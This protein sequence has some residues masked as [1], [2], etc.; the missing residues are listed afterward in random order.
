MN[1]LKQKLNQDLCL[2]TWVSSG[3]SA[4][5]E[6]AARSGFDWVLIDCEH[7]MG[8]YTDLVHQ[9][10]AIGQHTSTELRIDWMFRKAFARQA[11]AQEK[12]VA[13]EFVQVQAIKRGVKETDIELWADLTHALINT[14]E[15][16]FLR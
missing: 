10:Q 8:G 5:A 6:L 12:A 3:S 15:F 16:I 13:A 2:G 14:K 11:T 4:V 1:W 9:L 7:G